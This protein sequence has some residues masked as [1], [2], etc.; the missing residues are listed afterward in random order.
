[1]CP[2]ELGGIQLTHERANILQVAPASPVR[3]QQAALRHALGS[4]RTKSC[5]T[6]QAKLFTKPDGKAPQS[7]P[8]LFKPHFER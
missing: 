5:E 1:M 3:A 8:L 7:V 4:D 2:A 6:N